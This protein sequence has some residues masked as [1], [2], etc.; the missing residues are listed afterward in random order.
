MD[1]ILLRHGK[2]AG[3]LLRRYIGRTDEPLCAEG[4]AHAASTGADPNVS[5]VY[6]SPMRRA[7]ETARI[8]FPNAEL[9]AVDDLREMD[10]GDFEGRSADD[11]ASDAA[12]TA[13]VDGS[14]MERCPNGEGLDGFSARVCAAFNGLVGEAL[15]RGDKCLAVVAHGGTIMAILSRYGRPKHSFY[16]WYLPNCGYYL[17][18]LSDSAWRDVPA[19]ECITKH[20]TL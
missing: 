8:K 18:K 2:T 11:M 1:V 3:N 7:L 5:L 6:V 16:E 10:F 13:W 14:C 4:L 15:Q 9:R 20:E 17:A 12:Y 19:L